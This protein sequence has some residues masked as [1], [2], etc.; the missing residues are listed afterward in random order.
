MSKQGTDNKSNF[1]GIPFG[2]AMNRLRKMVLF[3]LLAQSGKNVC[4]RCGKEIMSVGDLS[5][6]HKKSWLNVEVSLFWDLNNIDFSHLHCNYSQSKDT[7]RREITH[8]TASG[9]NYRNCRCADCTTYNREQKRKYR[10]GIAQ[11]AE[12][13]SSN[14]D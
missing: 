6:E 9:Y 4:Y 14:L 11:Q 5:I 8:G 12:V 10:A 13:S 3:D 2:T 1:L 7:L